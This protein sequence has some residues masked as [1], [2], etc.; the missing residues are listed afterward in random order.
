MKINERKRLVRSIQQEAALLRRHQEGLRS[1]DPRRQAVIDN[2]LQVLHSLLR[3]IMIHT[4]VD[5]A[6]LNAM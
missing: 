6:I 4:G 5:A 2:D 1:E 3:E